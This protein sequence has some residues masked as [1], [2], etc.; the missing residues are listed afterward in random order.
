MAAHRMP[1]AGIFMLAVQPFSTKQTE[2]GFRQNKVS[3][4][5]VN[6]LLI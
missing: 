1:C 5:K 4:T 3:K 2:V 6:M